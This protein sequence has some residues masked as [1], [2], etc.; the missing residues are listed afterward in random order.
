M[1]ILGANRQFDWTEIP[2]A[3]DESDKHTSIYYS[4]DVELAAKTIKSIKHS[5]FTEIY[6][7]TNE[8][9]LI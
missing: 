2:I 1:N 7:L 5:N 8:K 4:Y 9:K 6:S 3:Y